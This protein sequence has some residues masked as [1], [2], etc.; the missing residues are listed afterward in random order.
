MQKTPVLCIAGPTATGKTALAVRLAKELGGEV[1][2][3]DS[4]QVYRRMDIGTAKPGLDERAG[5]PH[6]LIDIVEPTEPFTVAQYAAQAV[7]TAREVFARGRLPILSGG[8]GFY[9]RALTHGLS[10]GGVPSDPVLRERLKAEATTPD[11]RRALHERLRQ[12]DPKAAARLHENDVQRVSRAVE[13]FTL[14]GKPISMQEKQTEDCPFNLC[15]IGTTM[16][17]GHLYE[18]INARVDAMMAQGLLREVKALLGAG[19]P[20][21]AQAMQGIGYKELAAVALSGAPLHDAVTAVKQN[22]RHYAKRQW[23]WFRAE[24]R[25]TWLDME[26]TAS[27]AQALRLGE[28]FW[29]EAKQWI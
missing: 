21:S 12:I 3:M 15:L 25:F 5:I 13:V 1:I 11:G 17:R 6:H 2:S 7:H 26:N 14:T 10:L 28:A 29:K 19:V 9:L 23:T 27:E 22:T 18:R 16:E 8:T 20:P 24:P 4:M